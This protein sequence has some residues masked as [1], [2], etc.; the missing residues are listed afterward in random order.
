MLAQVNQMSPKKGRI[1]PKLL[2][3]RRSNNIDFVEYL[4][5]KLI[6]D[7]WIISL[8]EVGIYTLFRMLF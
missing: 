4:I 5:R 3:S 6:F 1:R 7:F 8:A 2:E